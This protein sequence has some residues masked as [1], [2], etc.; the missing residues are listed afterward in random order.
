MS[1]N[2]SRPHDRRSVSQKFNSISAKS[3]IKY[4][5]K[6]TKSVTLT[7]EGCCL[8]YN[9]LNT[10]PPTVDA[11]RDNGECDFLLFFFLI[12]FKVHQRW[13][14]ERLGQQKHNLSSKMCALNACCMRL[15]LDVPFDVHYVL[16]INAYVYAVT[17]MAS[18]SQF[19]RSRR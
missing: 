12:S 14:C 11:G 5:V 13:D 16:C 1:T 7:R 6:Q 18:H 4:A 3:A 17:W 10:T 15:F 8:R 2:R 9:T 19:R